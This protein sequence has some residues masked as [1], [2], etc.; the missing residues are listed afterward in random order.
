L[1]N[2]TNNKDVRLEEM[3]RPK[4]EAGEILVKVVASAICGTDVMEW[5]RIKKAPRIFRSRNCWRYSGVTIRKYKVGQGSLLATMFH[6]IYAS[7]VW[8]EI[9]RPVKL[10]IQEIIILVLQ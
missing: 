2:I 3:P 6:A 4:I 9:T 5:Y 1:P 7:T 8:Q 10:C